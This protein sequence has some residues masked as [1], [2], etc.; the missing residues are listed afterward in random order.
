[1]KQKSDTTGDWKA[2]LIAHV[3]FHCIEHEKDY[4]CFKNGILL[5]DVQN[6]GDMILI[7]CLR[8]NFSSWLNC[9]GDY[10]Q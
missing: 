1:M 4:N 5:Y 10:M 9:E 2:N 6:W 3:E 7:V 8:R